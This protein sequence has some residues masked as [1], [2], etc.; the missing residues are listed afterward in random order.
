MLN[1]QPQS[2]TNSTTPPQS[3]SATKKRPGTNSKIQKSY[4]QRQAQNFDP[5]S[6]LSAKPDEMAL[7]EDNSDEFDEAYELD[8]L[9]DEEEEQDEN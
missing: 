1:G 9:Y 3:R 7:E 6:D 8:D 2:H 4:K 5:D